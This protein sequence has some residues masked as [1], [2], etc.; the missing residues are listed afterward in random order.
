M[1][2]FTHDSTPV[3]RFVV[4][5]SGI[6]NEIKIKPKIT[7]IMSVPHPYCLGCLNGFSGR[8]AGAIGV[9]QLGHVGALSET[10]FEHSGQLI[11]AMI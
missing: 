11:N 2:L 3:F 6:T 5:L 9:P 4:G 10:S 8:S 1:P 7:T